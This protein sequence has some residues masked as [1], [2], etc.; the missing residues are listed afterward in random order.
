MPL[1]SVRLIDFHTCDAPPPH[2]PARCYVCTHDRFCDSRRPLF[3]NRFWHY[4]GKAS[5]GIETG[6]L[7][8]LTTITCAYMLLDHLRRR[9]C[10]ISNPNKKNPVHL[11]L[12]DIWVPQKYGSLIVAMF[13]CKSHRSKRGRAQI[14][15]HTW[16]LRIRDKH[17]RLF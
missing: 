5:R 13:K 6:G 12:P 3:H 17:P 9:A 1:A 8:R 11:L 2:S 14:E 4:I 15:G 7:P 10:Q 16:V